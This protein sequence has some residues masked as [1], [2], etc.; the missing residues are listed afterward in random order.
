V[1]AGADTDAFID[2]INDVRA[3]GGYY[4]QEATLLIPK[5]M[6]GILRIS[7]H[8]SSGFNPDTSTQ[9]IG[10]VDDITEYVTDS[11]LLNFNKFQFEIPFDCGDTDILKTF[12]IDDTTLTNYTGVH[13]SVATAGYIK[14]D[15]GRSLEGLEIWA[16]IE[17]LAPSPD[18]V[19]HV[20]ARTDHNGYYF[21]YNQVGK[22]KN[23]T[24]G[25]YGELS[26]YDWSKIQPIVLNRTQYGLTV[27]NNAKISNTTYIND[28]YSTVN[29]AVKDCNGNPVE[30]IKVAL[31]GSKAQV[32]QSNGI[33]QFRIRN[34][35]SRD[36]QVEAI[37]MSK[38]ECYTVDCDG[39]CNP[40]Y[41]STTAITDACYSGKPVI[42][43]SVMTLNIQSALKHSV[44]LK[45]GGLYPFG[46]VVVFGCG[47][48][49]SAVNELPQIQMDS[50]QKKNKL[51]FCSLSFDATGL[52]LPTDATCLKIVRGT[53]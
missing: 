27:I 48:K 37:I 14:D 51:S 10:T 41:P 17:D 32:T 4:Y 53:N 22:I 5:G 29:A 47:N 39:N 1:L 21:L 33:A 30:G 38:F 6:K 2:N 36:R 43:L 24:A 13:S 35:K 8:K 34:Y 26:C 52:V 46:F 18:N 44:G 3:D 19:N 45:A 40:C 23:S 20:F 7:S 9:V 31:S 25:I 42:T 50:T 28:F 49:I 15:I 16:T 12:I 11:G